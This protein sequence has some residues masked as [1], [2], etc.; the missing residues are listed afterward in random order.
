MS[1]RSN[2][3]V[4][5]LT[6]RCGW[7][8]GRTVLWLAFG[9]GVMSL[10]ITTQATLHMKS[11]QLSTLGAALLLAA[12]AL[13]ILTPP[14]T[15]AVAAVLVTRD[16]RGERFELLRLTTTLSEATIV[17]GAIFATLYRMRV[18][19]ALVVGL[20]PALV[21]GMLQVE[22]KVCGQSYNELARLW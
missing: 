11:I 17:R 20:M 21:V 7:P 22:I 8:S 19:L 1:I 16:M 6:R 10:A 5:R 14:I 9:L 4:V 12:W 13:A 2:P 15:V 3:V 18:L